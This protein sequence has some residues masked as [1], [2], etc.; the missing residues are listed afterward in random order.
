MLI[1]FVALLSTVSVYAQC[2]T[3]GSEVVTKTDELCYQADDGTITFKFTDGTFPSAFDYRV[4][5]YDF[6][7]AAFVYDDNNPA[8]LN[9]VP[10][11][12]I[13]A[14]SVFFESVPPGDYA[15][16]L[17][18]GA[19]GSPSPSSTYG[20]NHSGLPNT[21]VRI[22]AATEI[23]VDPAFVATTGDTQ[24][25]GPFDGEI[26]LT[27]ALS[28]G[29]GTYEYSINAGG[30]YQA[31]PVFSNLEDGLY[32]IRIRD[33]NGCVKDTAGIE[34]VD[35]AVA[36]TA[37]ISPAPA[38]ACIG[39]DLVL[40]GNPAGGTTVYTTHAWT[41]DTGP[42][43]ATNIENPTFNSGATGTFNLTY[44][45][46]DDKGC[47]GTDNITVNVNTAPDAGDDNTIDVCETDTNVNLFANLGGSPDGG[48]N[49]IDAGDNP[50]GTTFD[51]SVAGVGNYTF[52]YIVSGTGCPED[53]AAVTVNVNTAPDAGDDNTVEVCETETSV[54][55]F[56]S[57][58]GT[59]DGGGNWIDAGDNAV[60]AT[61]DA[62]TAGV[63][64]YVFRYLVNGAGCP[65]DTAAVTVNV[66]TAPDAG[67][68]NT[69][70]VCE[71][72]T[73]VDLF[74]SLLGTPDGGGNWIDAGDNAVGATFD[75]SAAG[76]GTFV[77]RY[78][79]SGT[80]CPEDTAAV[81]V[82]VNTAPDAGD[83]NTIEVCE[84][85]TSVDLFGNLGGTP[86]G[87]GN[88]IDAGDN[89]VGA[90]FDASTAGVGTYVFRYL[91]NG[92]GCPE[93]TAAVT[94]NVN[95]APD[96]GDDNTI[97]VC[98]SETSVDL[99]GSLLGT[100]DGG[101]NWID[102]GD[103]AVG[104]TFDASAAGVGT[105]VFRYLVS[106][107]GCP[108]DTA[109]VTVNVNTAPDA[110]DDNTIEVC[111]TETSVDLFGN[112]GGTPDGGGN[113][114]DAGD[115]AVG[116]TFDASA[117][118]VGT[119][120]FRYLVN[121]TGCPEDTAAVTVNVNTAPDA[122]DDNTIE[123][124]ETE[125]SVDLFGNLGGT[126]D[127]GGNWID[128][129]DN[130]VGAT[131]DANAAGA[132][133]YTFRYIVSGTGC[134]E[135]TAAVT[136]NV[137]T[138]PDA[139]DDNTIE[140][141]ETETSVDLFGSLLGTPDGG[142]NWIDA[143]DN[144][145]AATFDAN[146]AGVGTFVFRYLV[147]GTGC[148][149][150]TAAVTVNVNTAPVAGDDN[151]IDVCES[152][153]SVDLFGNLGG[154]PDIGG[155]WIDAGDN[156]VGATFD[157]SAAG[158]GTFVFRY[159][160]NG[161]GCPEDTA[162]VT[163]NV[164]TAPDAGDDNTVEVCETETSVDLF[165]SLLGTPDGGGNW[166]DAGDNAVG[167][168][169]DASAAGVG[170]FVFRYLV[171]GT[172]CPEDT[173]AVTVNVTGLA[174][175]GENGTLNACT[176]ETALDLTT[177]LSVSAQAGGTWTDDDASGQL[178][179][180]IF[181]A[182]AAGVG[183][184]N[185]TYTVTGTAPCAD[186]SATIT[187]TVVNAPN[188]G[189]DGSLDA[190]TNE[191][192]VDLFT[193][194]GGPFDGGGIWEDIDGTG[195][196]TGNLFDASLAAAGTFDFRYVV[197]A[198]GCTND[199][200]IVSVTVNEIP[201]AGN[202]STVTVCV[203]Q[204]TYDLTTALT[205]TAQAGGT[206]NDDDATGALTG[207]ILDASSAG[208]G[209]WQFTYTVSGT[210][211]CPDSSAVI[212][213]NVVTAPDAGDDN[214]IIACETDNSVDLF[215]NLGGIPD[216]GGVW[217]DIDGTGALTGSLFD[218]T[219]TAA[220]TFDFRYIVSATG[221]DNDTSVVSVTVNEI[222]DAGNDST[223]TVCVTQTAFDLT[224]ALT[225]TAQPGGTW[226]DDDGTGALSGNNFNASSA[227]VGAWHFTYTISGGGTCADSSA[228]ITVNVVTAP[229]AGNNNLITVCETD[230]SVDLFANLGGTPD[231]S[232]TW[233]DDDGTGALTLGIFDATAIAVPGT[234]N[235]TYT[236]SAA[237]CGNDMATVTVE[238][239]ATPDA[240][241]NNTVD[242]CETE[243]AFDLSTALTG[244]AQPGGTWNDDDTTGEL[245]GNTF[246]AQNAGAGTYDFTYTVAGSVSCPDSSA[247][248][249]VNVLPAPNAGADSIITV[250]ETVT[251]VDLAANL[252]GSPDAGGTWN[253]DDNTL[254]LTGS[255]FDPSAI[256]AG[257]YNFTYTVTGGVG[258]ADATAVVTVNVSAGPTAAN[259]G[260]D[261]LAC[262][263]GI[264]LYG[265]IPAV[266]TGL[267]T[268]V[269]GTGT[270]T[271]ADAASP[272]SLME[273]DAAGTYEIEWEITNGGCVSKD[274]VEITFGGPISVNLGGGLSAYTAGDNCD[275]PPGG[276]ITAFVSGG[277]AAAFSDY[278]YEW[279]IDN[280]TH[281]TNSPLSDAIN[282]GGIITVVVTDTMGCFSQG[283]GAIPSSQPNS[284]IINF[285]TSNIDCEGDSTGAVTVE[286]TAGAA[287]TI[288]GGNYELFAVNRT[289]DTIQQHVQIP[290][291]AGTVSYDLIGLGADLYFVSVKDLT[292]GA[293]DIC[294]TNGKQVLV[295]EP[296]AITYSNVN[297]T[298]VTC[299]GG[300]TGEISVEVGGGTQPY[301]SF[302]WTD[303]GGNPVPS[304]E[305]GNV[306]EITGQLAGIYQLKITDNSG[307]E[308][309]T[310]FEITEPAT[311]DPA[312]VTAGVSY[313]TCDS[314]VIGW[315]ASAGATGYRLDVA[316][317]I[318]FT[319]FLAGFQDKDVSTNL[320]DTI[321]GLS[322]SDTIYYRIRAITACGA[323]ANSDTAEVNTLPN[324][325]APDISSAPF[326]FSEVKC[327]SVI[328]SWGNVAGATG[329]ELDLSYNNFASVSNTF[330]TANT[331]DT[332]AALNPNQTI[333][334]RVRA[335]TDCGPTANSDTISTTTADVP[336]PPDVSV[337]ATEISCD[338]M[339]MN[340]GVV[341]GAKKYM[342]DVSL[343]NFVT[344]ETG[345]DNKDVG[346]A[347][348]DTISGLGL[349][350][351][352]YYRVRALTNCGLTTNSDTV[353][354]N[355]LDLP[356]AP[357]TS[358]ASDIGCDS[359]VVNWNAVTDATDYL[360]D[361]SEDINFATF[362]FQDK[363][364]GVATSDTLR[365]LSA[366]DTLYYR[367]RTVATCGNSI[368]SDTAMVITSDVPLAPDV[369]VGATDIRCDSMVVNWNPVAGTTDYLLDVSLDNFNT[370]VFQDKSMG[371]AVSDTI[372][373]LSMNDTV[374]YRVRAVLACG[375]TDYSDTV[376]ANTLDIP[377]APDVT[378]GA[379]GI[380]C[381]TLVANW[382]NVP[383]AT[384]YR[385]DVSLDNF[386]TFHVQDSVVAS[387][388]FVIR[389]LASGDSIYYR[390]RAEND[391]GVSG[392]S[393]TTIVRTL[394][395]A[396]CGF[397]CGF[398]AAAVG[399]N[400]TC[401]GDTDGNIVVF[402]ISGGSG[403]GNY[404][405]KIGGAASFSA[406]TGDFVTEIQN[407]AQGNYSVVIMDN[408]TGCMDTAMV[409][410]GVG[411][412]LFASIDKENI[413]CENGTGSVDLTVTGGSGNYTFSWTGPAG[414]TANTKDIFGLTE[415]GDYTVDIADTT[416]NCTAQFTVNIASPTD[417]TF[418]GSLVTNDNCNA[419]T[420]SVDVVVD[421]T[422]T[423]T[424]G[425]DLV[426]GNNNNL[427][428]GAYLVTITDA[429]GCSR[430]TTFTVQNNVS[431]TYSVVV[432]SVSCGATDDG[433]IDITVS[434]PNTYSFSGD[435]TTSSTQNLIA[436]DYNVTIRDDVTGCEKD[437]TISVF[438]KTVCGAGCGLDLAKFTIDPVNVNCP[439]GEDGAFLI[440]LLPGSGVDASRFQYSID[441]TAGW[442][443]GG[444]SS[445]L[446]YAFDDLAMGEYTI[447][448]KDF[449]AGVGCNEVMEIT[450]TIAAQNNIKITTQAESCEGSDGSITLDL[451]ATCMDDISYS[452]IWV[453]PVGNTIGVD[454]M[455]ANDLSAGNYTIYVQNS[456]TGLPI[457]TLNITVANNCSG[458]G[459]GNTDLCVLGNKSVDIA[460]TPFD[461]ENGGGSVTLTVIGGEAVEYNFRIVST[462][463]LIDMS[464]TETGSVTF[465]GLPSGEYEYQVI[466]NSGSPS[467][468]ATF[469]IGE[470]SVI[471][472]SVG[473]TM[474]GCDDPV[475]E[476]DLLVTLDV[477]TTA[478]GPYQVFAISSENPADTVAKA[479][480]DAGLNTTTLTG[481][482]LATDYE[483]EVH[484]A[485]TK[486][487]PGTRNVGIPNGEIVE[488][489]FDHTVSHI[490]CFGE[491]GV[492]TVS[493]IEASE[494]TPF[495]L[496]L[497]LAGDTEPWESKTYNFIPST[498][499]FNDLGYGDY[500]VQLVQEQNVCG[501]ITVTENSP[502]ITI[503]GPDQL[504]NASIQQE[505]EV[506]VD[507]PLGDIIV[508]DITGGGKP[509]KVR[510]LSNPEGDSTEWVE[511]V[512]SNPFVDPYEYVFEDM[513]LGNYKVEVRD[514]FGC[515][516]VE[517]VVVK[518]TGELFIPNIFTPNND[519]ENDAFEIVNLDLFLN[520][521]EGANMIITNRW[522]NIIY[523]SDNYSNALPW[524][525][526]ES[527]EGMYFYRLILPNGGGTF[528]G[529]LELWR[530]R[531]P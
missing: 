420:G 44:T 122:G 194:I 406:F 354:T 30:S 37:T 251:A 357:V 13:G 86:D 502:A 518:Y 272:T 464:D 443:S 417:F 405:Y 335:I 324:E 484:S 339:I 95:T 35:D 128:A 361:V 496:H 146:T 512:N 322:A 503:V 6:D 96:A 246:N 158:V 10:A 492:I 495:T 206:W 145:V 69:I 523:E 183:T 371:A 477:A 113:W 494:D 112:L 54:D 423:Y 418:A 410:V 167:A 63:G 260:A 519:G 151:A 472:S 61:F 370:F 89:A 313:V 232:G 402:V 157:A 449:Q 18:G 217:E 270:L 450:K 396:Q 253:D 262:D 377:I 32:T 459:S 110:G 169:F 24:C 160:V 483:I 305:V 353:I 162:A 134:P 80:G 403:N 105:F 345:F 124:C 368:Y 286:I 530:G 458:G 55:L 279:T 41:G 445:G 326:G 338:G 216:G 109:A 344:T 290:I 252:G 16:V 514:V 22:D 408:V 401:E 501:G 34:V 21:A 101:G 432:D 173:A 3:P 511:I 2:P 386:A 225:G 397:A 474:P 293:T 385:I 40:N 436:G 9:S 191:T 196:L 119:F 373:G 323:T 125:T 441:T 1:F 170:T 238:V 277:F 343:D 509:Y 172:G 73:S 106:G 427:T 327:D 59:P 292:L 190:C 271:F 314:L 71:S 118:G 7:I 51:P 240:G 215:A 213:V 234:Y 382:N 245:T 149:E 333:F 103:N 274:T 239:I 93:D 467:C 489:S 127:G 49:W 300:S 282:P 199:T 227:G 435:L 487:C 211:A 91:V 68:D 466:D 219:L 527:P 453:D 47:T 499:L 159:L 108:E 229:D 291:S 498:H 446:V 295:T 152:E 529:W 250:C 265:N 332:I 100:P 268:Q 365:G 392:N 388:S 389:G 462:D 393:D 65:E 174:D 442:N 210:G 208:V 155:N 296:A 181:N 214:A 58:L 256:G 485:D 23:I 17:S 224:T 461:C 150:D 43:S 438:A 207:N 12:T 465:S 378:A 8:F 223:V 349:G 457:E 231:G 115:N 315:N 130:A 177:G 421:G 84:T 381:D 359:L 62:S 143:G 226:N 399:G 266:G 429:A 383:D 375:T 133:S 447:F 52:R 430:D 36:P 204:T 520:G 137:N 288:G 171:S 165:G 248:I 348:S 267:W 66:N 269:S 448:I 39:E 302:E 500:Q 425:G 200:S 244:S 228:V 31:S 281:T 193:G 154:T 94:V 481:L 264:N 350:D 289:G 310:T 308:D 506:T 74:G 525:G 81:T 147:S 222:P 340:W 309:S 139:G 259:A 413:T 178:T 412:T 387:N 468:Q 46:T 336:A 294:A 366:Q 515:S 82:N 444:S 83:D 185:F 123:V 203:T 53:T 42:L 376:S 301:A 497:Y 117:A 329:Y 517:D 60:G 72:E 186:S 285:T 126:P 88:W 298:D 70:E 398:D 303:A 184:Y 488:A 522:G 440:N 325:A 320:S 114:I 141:C 275:D 284:P 341:P 384:T 513:A 166:I 107:T 400:V 78:L 528:T 476:A 247:V 92:A 176:A 455:Q 5:L 76:V 255:I 180:N 79:V 351:T 198:A 50:V 379:S 205:G 161:T 526:G 131:F 374:Y 414:Y 87:G 307:C 456:V 276:A 454:M 424:I 372:G 369:T 415:G 297:I 254:A 257:T 312:P 233:N 479:T 352:V 4:Q 437:T 220:G 45:V 48:G 493:N 422:G 337:G 480:I 531:R 263:L 129:G 28:G 508:T 426:E 431:F 478:T 433:A 33:T 364:I 192:A 331:A 469:S 283:A 77:F 452:F 363:N 356:D 434:G 367:V 486:A 419:G 120:V 97:E 395:P 138:A 121:G 164:N 197:S 516:I 14:D 504:L 148:P 521:D 209:T 390:V 38:E 136:V 201:D 358:G 306:T 299:K 347:L 243:A 249:T 142:G 182:Q 317:D 179:G 334:V 19:C 212:T 404:L 507:N 237:G 491:G 380:G 304:S 505:V 460:T 471:I 218:A 27:G 153:T 221:C 490:Q 409:S 342:L 20:L 104:A 311:G 411:T 98:E 202:D 510:M 355:T 11:P 475:Q 26:D 102:A 278:T 451:S 394:L 241:E 144:A 287:T 236:V 328:V 189:A 319:T 473:I 187:V 346:L 56:G 463:G 168:T 163:V 321:P 75:A 280:V 261:S 235:F 391:C 470:N 330:S 318:S 116:A 140:V 64:T 428:E 90:T 316:E 25:T 29:T 15:L 175:A 362:V 258:C 57:L 195:A 188:A 132:G 99:F 439:G 242:I 111:E 67:D 135:D 85:E 273:A 416:N 156:A 360:L 407:Q 482:P 230:N 524:N